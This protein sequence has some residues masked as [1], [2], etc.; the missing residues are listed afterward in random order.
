MEGAEEEGGWGGR[1]GE[2]EER[3]EDSR[4]LSEHLGRWT[5]PHW[6]RWAHEIPAETQFLLMKLDQDSS[7]TSVRYAAIFP[8]L[9][10]GF[11]SC[12]TAR[13]DH[14]KPLQRSSPPLPLLN[15]PPFLLL[16]LLHQYRFSC[17]FSSCNLSTRTSFSR[18][19]PARA[20]SSRDLLCYLPI[21]C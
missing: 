17:T 11:R 2:E 15:S 14:V 1:E 3:E 12:L 16:P 7:S 21:C 18:T 19:S 13:K 9:S 6:G 8:V 4:V 10:G 5:L 20:S